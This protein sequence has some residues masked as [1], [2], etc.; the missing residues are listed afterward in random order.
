VY[1]T[2]PFVKTLERMTNPCFQD[3]N[4]AAVIKGKHVLN[5]WDET[6]VKSVGEVFGSVKKSID[7]EE[8]YEFNPSSN[9]GSV[10]D[11]VNPTNP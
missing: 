7:D 9:N 4:F 2:I 5:D 11:E 6:M 1:E 3:T 10:N 8:N